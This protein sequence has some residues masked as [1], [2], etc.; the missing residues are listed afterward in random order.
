MVDSMHMI[1]YN[2]LTARCSISK[3]LFSVDRG[4]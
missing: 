1:Q 2:Q 3:I 4:Q